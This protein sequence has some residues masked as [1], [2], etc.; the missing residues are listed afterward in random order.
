[1]QV[2]LVDYSIKS[3]TRGKDALGEVFLKV[4]SQ[5][6]SIFTGRGTSTDIIEA[7]AQAF[8]NALNK[9]VAYEREKT[10][11]KTSPQL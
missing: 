3:V 9:I 1:M 10:K 6:G 5:K 2:E 8:I 4:R 11:R 7:S